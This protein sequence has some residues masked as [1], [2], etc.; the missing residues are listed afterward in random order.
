MKPTTSLTNA[1]QQQQM[2]QQQQIPIN[3]NVN[4]NSIFSNANQQMASNMQMPVQ[5][6]QKQ[7][8]AQQ[9]P[10]PQMQ[11]PVFNTPMNNAHQAQVR[12][13]S[14]GFYGARQQAPINNQPPQEIP[15]IFND[16]EALV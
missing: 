3:N 6:M 15:G 10:I 16:D 14:G 4:V 8:P 1:Q 7:M 13:V 12:N 5:Q 11:Q 9:M 2:N